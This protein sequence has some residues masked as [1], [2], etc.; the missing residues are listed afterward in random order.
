MHAPHLA[1]KYVLHGGPYDNPVPTPFILWNGVV[2]IGREVYEP[3]EPVAG[4]TWVER[5]FDSLRDV[6]HLWHAGRLRPTE[7]TVS[8]ITWEL[9]ET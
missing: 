6:T 7:K 4:E 3:R 2:V 1:M 5:D 8:S 9:E